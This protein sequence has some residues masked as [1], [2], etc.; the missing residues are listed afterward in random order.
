M[1][2][3]ISGLNINFIYNTNL[4]KTSDYNLLT[5]NISRFELTP[6]SKKVTGSEDQYNVLDVYN[7]VCDFT[8]GYLFWSYK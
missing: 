4:T 3:A 2:M 1:D 6:Q 5:K 8:I 7:F